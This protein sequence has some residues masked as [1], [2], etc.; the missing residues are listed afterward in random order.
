MEKIILGDIEKCY[1]C[2]GAMI[3]N[4]PYVFF[5]GEGKGRLHVFHGEGFRQ[6]ETI[7]EG[8][9][10]TMSIVANPGDPYTFLASRGFYSMYDAS[11]SAIEL[12][13]Y[14]KSGFSH[15]PIAYLPWLHRFDVVCGEDGT[16]YI[17]AATL[18]ESK[19]SKEDWSKP[20]HVYWAELTESFPL[21]LHE[22]PG[23]FFQNHGFFRAENL[24]YIG[25]REGAFCITPPAK[26]GGEWAVEQVLSFPVSDLAVYDIDGDGVDEIAC[27]MPF[28]GDRYEVYKNGEKIYTY[29]VEN[30]FYHTVI[31]GE[32][33]GKPVFIGGAR[34]KTASLFRLFWENGMQSEELD[35]GCGPSNAAI[36]NTPEADILLAANRQ[37]GQAALY[38]FPRK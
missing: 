38:L 21:T 13:K 15:E 25:A 3:D 12:V 24:V 31:R 36:L 32:I 8:M 11:T 35:S 18:A 10:G 19:E 22:L 16:K 28:H 14:E 17:V 33:E 23:D 6:M 4:E 2:L 9:G 26:A 30:D 20:G 5:A 29:G 37:I 34:Q 27:I 1:A 7:W